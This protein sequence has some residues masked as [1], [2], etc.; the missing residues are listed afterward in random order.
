M[1]IILH[2]KIINFYVKALRNTSSAIRVP[3]HAGQV[4]HDLQRYH[5][6]PIV[7][8]KEKLVIDAE[9][10]LIIKGIQ[11]YGSKKEAKALI[12]SEARWI[13]WQQND[14]QAQQSRWL[15]ILTQFTDEIEIIDQDQAFISLS[16]HPKPFAIAEL[17]SRKLNDKGFNHL[18]GY[19]SSKWVAKIASQLNADWHVSFLTPKRFLATLPIT[20]LPLNHETIKRLLWFG[21]SN[22]K[23]L[24]QVPITALQDQFGDEAYLI[25]QYC[26][27]HGDHQIT[28]NYPQK[29]YSSPFW[30]EYEID[31]QKDIDFGLTAISKKLAEFATDQEECAHRIRLRIKF[32]QAEDQIYERTFTQAIL[33]HQQYQY[34]LK[35]LLP[36]A[37][38]RSVIGFVGSA[39]DIERGSP[40][41]LTFSHEVLGEIRQQ[42][43]NRTIQ[44]LQKTFGA[45]SIRIGA[46]TSP[47]KQFL[48][49]FK[50]AF[51]WK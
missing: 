8:L 39:L 7:L 6:L 5:C 50:D 17:L 23:Q 34:C 28:I 12:G 26:L 13:E 40:T 16:A 3:P 1:H 15:D 31:N 46:E 29:M 4:T 30:F 27:G 43:N 33:T 44:E 19:G 51:G 21:Y 9:P 14:Y 18:I 10:S 42:R 35:R 45:Q 47:R 37:M 24:S 22:V 38:P 41:Q 2:I 11:I 49:R 32:S 36:K 20:Y 25:S 48:R